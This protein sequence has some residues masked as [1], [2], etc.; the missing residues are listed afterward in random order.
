MN[1]R[2]PTKTTF[3][4]PTWSRIV[5]GRIVAKVSVYAAGIHSTGEQVL[6][7]ESDPFWSWF[8]AT[9]HFFPPIMSD[10]FLPRLREFWARE[11]SSRELTPEA[12]VPPGDGNYISRQN[13][14]PQG[15]EALEVAVRRYGEN[16]FTVIPHIEHGNSTMRLLVLFCQG[17]GEVFCFRNGKCDYFAALGEHQEQL[18]QQVALLDKRMTRLQTD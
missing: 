8:Y 12:L 17:L 4:W 1:A 15:E 3:L 11:I 16:A 5:D 2:R 7:T 9:R 10:S 14:A 18:G 6:G 13:L